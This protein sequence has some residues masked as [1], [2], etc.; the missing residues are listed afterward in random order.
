[1]SGSG[2]TPGRGAV[3]GA[4]A[5]GAGAAVLPNTGGQDW[6][7]ITALAAIAFG[8]IMLAF[9]AYATFERKRK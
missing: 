9:R 8:V 6:L 1:M 3:L 7:I 4:T 2:T 5:T